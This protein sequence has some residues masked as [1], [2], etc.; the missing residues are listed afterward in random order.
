[1][2]DHSAVQLWSCPI[3]QPWQPVTACC[4]PLLNA[5][6]AP[7]AW[8]ACRSQEPWTACGQGHMGRSSGQTSTGSLLLAHMHCSCRVCLNPCPCCSFIFGQTGAGNN[9]AKGH[10]TEGAELIDSVLDVVRK[11]AESCDCLQGEYCSPG[12]DAGRTLQSQ[13]QL[14]RCICCG[15]YG[16]APNPTGIGMIC[17]CRFPGL[18]LSGRRH[19]LRHG[20]PAHQQDPR[21]VRCP[22]WHRWMCL[23]L[24]PAPCA[25]LPARLCSTVCDSLGKALLPACLPATC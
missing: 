13:Q 2:F 4:L 19:R 12:R 17:V 1:M 5:T 10:Y 7:A 8:P 23:A 14:L 22:P 3:H 24:R 9:W 21:R 6:T 18:P 11:E 16:P 25:C 20:D 15:W